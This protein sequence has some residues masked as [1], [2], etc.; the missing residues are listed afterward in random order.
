LAILARL[1]FATELETKLVALVCR[2]ALFLS[3][4]SS[5][6]SKSRSGKTR[7]LLRLGAGRAGRTTSEGALLAR[8]DFAGSFEVAREETVGRH[9][10]P[11]KITEAVLVGGREDEP[12]NTVEAV[13]VDGKEDEL[14]KTAEAV[15]LTGGIP[16]ATG[17]TEELR[18]AD[19]GVLF[20][21]VLSLAGRDEV[22]DFTA[23][24]LLVDGIR[25]SVGK[26][27]DELGKMAEVMHVVVVGLAL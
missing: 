14:G 21:G 16:D 4:H 23:E 1:S 27:D 13:L 12:G 5:W 7:G 15:V 20:N 11:G 19:A 17:K 6:S 26:A 10:E 25:L 9:D 3:T 24:G 22:L 8:D 2:C 18:D